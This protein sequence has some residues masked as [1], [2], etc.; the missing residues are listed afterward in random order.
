MGGMLQLCDKEVQQEVTGGCTTGSRSQIF[1]AGLAAL[2]QCDLS[3]LN[4]NLN[5]TDDFTFQ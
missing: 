2:N 5:H 1:I 4:R 3:D